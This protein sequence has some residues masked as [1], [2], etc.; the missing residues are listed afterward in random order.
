MRE[1]RE[2]ERVLTRLILALDQSISHLPF[3]NFFLFFVLLFLKLFTED[4]K[5]MKREFNVVL[6]LYIQRT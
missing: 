1:E 2:R 5:L 4:L 6:D 3:L